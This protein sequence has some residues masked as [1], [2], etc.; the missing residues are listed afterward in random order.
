MKTTRKYNNL[1][2]PYC[3]DGRLMLCELWQIRDY[4]PLTPPAWPGDYR[5]V[6]FVD[7]LTPEDVFAK[8]QDDWDLKQSHPIVV[9]FRSTSVG[10]VVITPSRHVHR[11]ERFGWSPIEVVRHF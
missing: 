3:V 5:L 1:F 11:C 7:C 9:D 6:G 10:D 4:P 2:A 8:T